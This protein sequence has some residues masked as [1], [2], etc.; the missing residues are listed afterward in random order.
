MYQ[1]T[2]ACSVYEPRPL[3]VR[4]S[5]PS[6]TLANMQQCSDPTQAYLLVTLCFIFSSTCDPPSQGRSQE[7]YKG[8]W[9]VAENFS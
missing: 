3:L 5:V 8:V 1:L 4:I 7:F 6:A 2:H 9:L